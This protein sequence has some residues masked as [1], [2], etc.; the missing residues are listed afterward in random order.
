MVQIGDSVGG[1]SVVWFGRNCVEAGMYW[2]TCSVNGFGGVG[3][4]GRYVGFCG[5]FDFRMFWC[6][7]C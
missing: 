5:G 6:S 7:L 1:G 4:G 2:N 3:G